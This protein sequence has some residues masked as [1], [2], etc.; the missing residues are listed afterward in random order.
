VIAEGVQEG[1]KPEHQHE[2]SDD[3]P[4]PMHKSPSGPNQ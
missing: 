3:Y 1:T 4:W 2:H